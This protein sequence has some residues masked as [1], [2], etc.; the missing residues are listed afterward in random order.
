VKH[1][2]RDPLG[3]EMAAQLRDAAGAQAS[4]DVVATHPYQGVSDAPPER[5]DDGNRW[6]VTRVEAVR[7]LMVANGDGPKPIWFTE[8]GWS[9]HA[10]AP[11]TLPYRLGV[12]EAQQA[13]YAARL[14]RLVRATYPYV[15]QVFW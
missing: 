15:T 9:A 5:S 3:C 4:F 8:T 2:D 7:V 11:G 6:W 13:D 14:I 10:N 12:T 1:L